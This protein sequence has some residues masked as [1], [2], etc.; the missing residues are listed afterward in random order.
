MSVYGKNG[1]GNFL[2]VSLEIVFVLIIL[3]MIGIA[4]KTTKILIFYPNIICLL[5]IMYAFIGLFDALAKEEPFCKR[6]IKKIS[7]CSH[8]VK[9]IILYFVSPILW[10]YK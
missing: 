4:F 6:T 3:L 2:K 5:V 7:K 9:V 10:L 1:L 8:K